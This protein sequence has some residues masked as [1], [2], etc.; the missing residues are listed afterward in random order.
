MNY[1][2]LILIAFLLMNK[3][4]GL[5]GLLSNVNLESLAPL[6]SLTGLDESALDSV[7]ALLSSGGDLKSL[8]PLLLKTFQPTPQPS[9]KEQA[10][11]LTPIKDIASSEIISTL[12]NYFEN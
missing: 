9:T 10:N 12:G 4:E 11:H 2:P 3:G 6:L 5:N 7:K 8:L 1:L